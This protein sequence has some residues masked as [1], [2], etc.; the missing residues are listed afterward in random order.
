MPVGHGLECDAG[1][2]ERLFMPTAGDEL[3]TDGEP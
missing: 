3:D 1:L 2:E